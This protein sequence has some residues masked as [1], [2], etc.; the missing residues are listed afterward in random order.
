MR[1][2]VLAWARR[3]SNIVASANQESLLS[4]NRK[5]A[6]EVEKKRKKVKTWDYQ[7][8]TRLDRIIPQSYKP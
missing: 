3:S 1:V 4:V 7:T 2:L 6:Y 5:N 8:R